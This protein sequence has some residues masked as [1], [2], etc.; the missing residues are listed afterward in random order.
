V[1]YKILDK[2]SVVNYLLDIPEIKDFFNDDNLEAKEIGDGNLN[3]VYLVNSKRD[4]KKALIVKQAVPY[5]RCVGED[6]PLS[7]ERMTFEIRALKE[8]KKLE[9]LKKDIK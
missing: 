2:N 1:K 4:P 9:D 5:L 8:F 7:K 6:F 3:F